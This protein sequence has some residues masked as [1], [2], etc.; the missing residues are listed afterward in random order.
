MNVDKAE[1]IRNAIRTF[2]KG[3]APEHLDEVPLAQLGIDSLDFFELLIMLEEQH[4]IDIPIEKLENDLT[5]GQL[6]KVADE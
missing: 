2:L 3:T 5:I 6:I 4:G 1:I